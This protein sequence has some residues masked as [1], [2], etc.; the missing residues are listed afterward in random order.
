MRK[1]LYLDTDESLDGDLDVGGS[2]NDLYQLCES[3]YTGDLKTVQE[4]I[5]RDPKLVSY[6][7]ITSPLGFAVAAGKAEVAEFP[8]ESWRQSVLLSSRA[9]ASEG[10]RNS[11]AIPRSVNS[12]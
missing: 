4:L 6:E 1:P 9:F 10:R 2:G 7:Y 11:R 5:N 12:C 3:A 8:V